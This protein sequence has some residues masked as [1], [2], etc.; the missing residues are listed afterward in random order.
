[1]TQLLSDAE[2]AEL[3]GTLVV[4]PEAGDLVR[5]AGGVRKLRWSHGRRNKGKRGGLRVIY[6]WYSPDSVI[7]M[8]LA[9]SKDE[10][11]DLTPT[12][13]RALARLVTEEFK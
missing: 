12:Q 10:R 7:Y 9:Y 5:E 4:D 2:Y 3:Q 8:L 6:Y 13:R 1:M 11:D